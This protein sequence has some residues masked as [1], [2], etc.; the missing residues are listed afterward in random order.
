M[1]TE[2]GI[3]LKL[4]TTGEG[5][6]RVRTVRSSAC[7]SCTSKDSCHAGEGGGMAMDVDAINTARAKPGDRV[8]LSIKTGSFV[9]AAFLIYL[10][11]VLCL[12]VGAFVGQHMAEAKG[13][14]PSSMAAIV[15]FLA[16]AVA[17]VIIR[18]VDR[19][20]SGNTNYIPEII[21]IRHRSAP[22]EAMADALSV[23]SSQPDP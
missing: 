21:K 10:F 1:A 19:L 8:V 14:D 7:E 3:V 2:E 18:L 4:D 16:F 22:S 13:T 20:M 9:K 12:I 11:P 15:G 17:F 23:D 6:A 5:T